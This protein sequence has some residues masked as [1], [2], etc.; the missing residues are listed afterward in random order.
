MKNLPKR[1][2]PCPIAEAII[3]L[4]FNSKLPKGAIFGILYNAVRDTFNVVEKLPTSMLP[5]EVIENDPN[6]QFKPLYKI[7]DGKYTAQI[8]NDVIS[9]HSPN[10]YVGW[11]EFSKNILIF[12]KKIELSAVVNEPINFVLRYLNF[13]ETD[14]YP[15]INLNIN[16]LNEDYKSSNLVLRTEI[17]KDNFVEILQIAN[18]VTINNQQGNRHGSLLDIT[19]A[20][21]KPDNFFNNLEQIISK[22][23]DLEKE[24]FFGL[25]K[26]E[27][28]ITLNPEY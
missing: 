2:N 3:E 15:K 21:N 16:L 6:F 13:F 25:L 18:S 9:F 19:C 24:L 7:T 12:F 1:I 10:T 4:K 14:I 8:G 11:T 28:L 17:L 5:V 27:F 26:D 20:L 23:H 22:S